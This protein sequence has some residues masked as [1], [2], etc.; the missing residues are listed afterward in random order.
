MIRRPPRSTRTDTLFPYTTLF[1]SDRAWSLTEALFALP[2]D[3]KRRYHIA[4]GGG[5][6][7][8][9]PFKTEIAKDAEAV[10][11]KEFCDVGRDMP[12]G[13]KYARDMAPNVW[14]DRPVGY[15]AALTVR[16]PAFD[17]AR[18]RLW[19]ALPGHRGTT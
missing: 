16:F 8:Y 14:P 12:E 9:T 6:R 5:A 3:E 17:T 19:F 2:E 15:R 10:D 4:G 1:R 11:L 13:H 7:G 18:G